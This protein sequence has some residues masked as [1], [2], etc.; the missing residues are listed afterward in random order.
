V[1]VCLCDVSVTASCFVGSAMVVLLLSFLLSWV[2]PVV[3]CDALF[4][5]VSSVI[6]AWAWWLWL[7]M[8][9]AVVAVVG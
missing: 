4:L 1:C 3:A 5:E 8:M 6:L 2:G 7:M 9:V